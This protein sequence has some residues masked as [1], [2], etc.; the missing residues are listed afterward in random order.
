MWCFNFFDEGEKKMLEQQKKYS[1]QK[2]MNLRQKRVM[3]KLNF[4]DTVPPHANLDVKTKEYVTKEF[5]VNVWNIMIDLNKLGVYFEFDRDSPIIEHHYLAAIFNKQ[6]MI[7]IRFIMDL[8]DYSRSTFLDE[9]VDLQK[10]M[11]ARKSNFK[12]QCTR[13]KLT[14]SDMFYP[15]DM[16][17]KYTKQK[18]MGVEQ[19]VINDYKWPHMNSFVKTLKYVE[20]NYARRKDHLYFID[21]VYWSTDLCDAIENFYIQ[22]EKSFLDFISR[23]IEVID[24]IEEEEEEKHE[25]DKHEDKHERGGKFPDIGKKECEILENRRAWFNDNI[26]NSWFEHLAQKHK[27]VAYISTFARI[28]DTT[29]FEKFRLKVNKMDFIGKKIVLIPVHLTFHWTLVVMDVE[30]F[31]MLYI[32]SMNDSRK[33]AET[34]IVLNNAKR[35][36]RTLFN[37]FF[38]RRIVIDEQQDNTFDCGPF[39]CRSAERYCKLKEIY[40]IEV[41]ILT[42]RKQMQKIL[43]S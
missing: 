20:S 21:D 10:C 22:P 30:H 13:S 26:I 2:K 3:H 8:Y 19:L 6:D 40:K 11:L 15:Q 39:L 18:V 38:T 33:E 27:H 17:T 7:F 42:F 37:T 4:M 32:D 14:Q 35:L 1:K 25:E 23:K 41:D 28:A 29:E 34:E 36:A 9:L 43:C 12:S 5:G 16:E 24:L 31:R